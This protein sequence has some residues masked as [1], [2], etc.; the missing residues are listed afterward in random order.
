MS[1]ATALPVPVLQPTGCWIPSSNL[2]GPVTSTH[3]AL[4]VVT[5]STGALCRRGHF[6]R[7][8]P[9]FVFSKPTLHCPMITAVQG[10]EIPVAHACMPMSGHAVTTG[11]FQPIFTLCG[12][13]RRQR[14]IPEPP[15][16]WQP[17]SLHPSP[18]PPGS[19][20]P[21]HWHDAVPTP[22]PNPKPPSLTIHGPASTSAK[23][24]RLAP[25]RDSVS[26][27]MAS[28]P[29]PNHLPRNHPLQVALASTPPCTHR[30]TTLARLAQH[31]MECSPNMTWDVG[32]SEE[33]VIARAGPPS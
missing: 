12:D 14:Q 32:L 9:E 4:T 28:P 26:Q 25:S 23:L 22:P 10:R 29:E 31:D 13:C 33:R 11:S 19:K 30:H 6:T 7:F 16:P 27:S 17:L 8:T 20:H 18:H 3:H 21:H 24:V 2:S 15:R 5:A 1:R